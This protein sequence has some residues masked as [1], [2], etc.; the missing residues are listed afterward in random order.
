MPKPSYL[1]DNLKTI[2]T[3]SI[4]TS[5]KPIHL[6]FPDLDSFKG[7]LAYTTEIIP[8]D[9][10]L[11]EN[12]MCFLCLTE[13]DVEVKAGINESLINPRYKDE[14]RKITLYDKTRIVP[15]ISHISANS[16]II[17]INGDYKALVDPSDHHCFRRI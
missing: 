16:C 9:P 13:T 14:L 15:I 3:A 6:W 1:P 11:K 8:K 12:T 4:D 17:L 2:L 5:E 10:I 7:D